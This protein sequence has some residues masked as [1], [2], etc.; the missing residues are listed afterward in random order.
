MKYRLLVVD[1]EESQ[2]EM[3]AGFL[4][5]QG[6]QVKMAEAGKVAL[7]L[8]LENYFEVALIDLRMPGPD[9]M[10]VLRTIKDIERH[11]HHAVRVS[12]VSGIEGLRPPSGE[13]VAQLGRLMIM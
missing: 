9:G 2:R 11:L 10:S 13:S 1:D 5:K 6:Y 8:C 4:A 7:N 12:A 3:L